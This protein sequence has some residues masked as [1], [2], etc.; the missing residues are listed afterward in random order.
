MQAQGDPGKP[1]H[2]Q[3]RV[4]SSGPQQEQVLG[5]GPA[6]PCPLWP[7]LCQWS[8]AVPVPWVD[9]AGALGGQCRCPVPVPQVGSPGT[10][11]GQS[12][13]S[14][15]AVPVQFPLPFLYQQALCHHP[16]RHRD[17]QVE[18]HATS[19]TGVPCP[20]SLPGGW[21]GR[22]LPSRPSWGIH[23]QQS[24]VCAGCSCSPWGPSSP[25]LSPPVLPPPRGP[26]TQQC[27]RSCISCIPQPR[28]WL[29]P[30]G[31][32]AVSPIAFWVVFTLSIRAARQEDAEGGWVW[33]VAPRRFLRGRWMQICPGSPSAPGPCR[34]SKAE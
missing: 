9:S 34:G 1:Q 31:C 27:I 12:W 13:C 32:S 5:K 21:C 2:P 30:W 8:R 18:P 14:G 29:H 10:P 3:S 6:P 24:P 19:A 23:P 26:C 11:G 20:G 22:C 25:G 16:R 4:G 7:E 15:R 17:V 33:V 28:A